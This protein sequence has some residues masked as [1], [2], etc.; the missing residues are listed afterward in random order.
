MMKTTLNIDDDTANQ[1]MRVTGE[2]KPSSSY[3]ART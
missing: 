1:L 3:P 2:K